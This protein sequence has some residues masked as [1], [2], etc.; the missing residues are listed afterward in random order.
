MAKE[1]KSKAQ[2]T[3]A[4]SEGANTISNKDMER[5][6]ASLGE[7]EMAKKLNEMSPSELAAYMRKMKGMAGEENKPDADGYRNGGRVNISNFKGSF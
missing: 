1:D 5:M 7:A 4:P 3:T 6:K 2:M